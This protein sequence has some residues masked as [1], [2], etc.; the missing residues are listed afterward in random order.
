M[1]WAPHCTSFTNDTIHQLFTDREPFKV[2]HLHDSVG[3]RDQLVSVE[4]EDLALE[5]PNAL[6]QLLQLVRLEDHPLSKYKEKVRI[7]SLIFI[8]TLIF[9]FLHV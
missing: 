4:V 7:V 3:E 1:S 5:P 9:L 8:Y 6:G 2:R